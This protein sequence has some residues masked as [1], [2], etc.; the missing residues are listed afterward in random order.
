MMF[1][2]GLSGRP[3]ARGK[4]IEVWAFDLRTMAFRTLAEA[5]EYATTNGYRKAQFNSFHHGVVGYWAK[6]NRYVYFRVS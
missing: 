1:D 4:L 6:N 3:I 5:L 2:F